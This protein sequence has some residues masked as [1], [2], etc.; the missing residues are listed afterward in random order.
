MIEVD[1]DLFTAGEESCVWPDANGAGP[2]TWAAVV[3]ACKA[4]CH[5]RLLDYTGSLPKTH[6]EYLVA[7]RGPHLFLNLIDPP[8]PL[9]QRESF[10]AALDFIEAWH[11]KGAVLLHC[12]QGTSR[13]PSLA[14]LYLAKR[15][16]SIRR[17]TYRAAAAEYAE[18]VGGYEPGR[19]IATFLAAHWNE[20][21]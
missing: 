9:F 10:T 21:A 3:H 16:K 17:D 14:L 19:G 13:A 4:P 12:N 1:L 15:A 5:M 6:P 18:R 7:T 11:P 8:F 2:G 20:L